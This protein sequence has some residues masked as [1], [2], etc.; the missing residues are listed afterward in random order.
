IEAD[1]HGIGTEATPTGDVD[2]RVE[3]EAPTI[4]T[5][6]G[7]TPHAQLSRKQHP[8]VILPGNLGIHDLIDHRL[9]RRRHLTHR[10]RRCRRPRDRLLE[11]HLRRRILGPARRV[12]HRLEYLVEP[13]TRALGYLV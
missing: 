9:K 2:H 1:D 7:F 11:L 5:F 13:A 12:D 4:G 10:L 3:H 6:P 8:D